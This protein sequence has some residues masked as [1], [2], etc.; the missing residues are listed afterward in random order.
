MSDKRYTMK[1][2]RD[3][4]DFFQQYIDKNPE[5]G[6]NKVSQLAL[7][8]LQEKAFELKKEMEKQSK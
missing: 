7:H 5:I 8:I 1:I 3:L 2:P 6:F 4:R